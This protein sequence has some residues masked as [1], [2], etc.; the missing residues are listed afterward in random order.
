[1]AV[2]TGAQLAQIIVR[3]D[4]SVV[5][6]TPGQAQ[7]VPPHH[8]DVRKFR[9]LRTDV[10]PFAAVPLA[11]GTGTPAA[12]VRERV[13][14]DVT[15]AP[16]DLELILLGQAPHFDRTLHCETYSGIAKGVHAAAV[17]GGGLRSPWCGRIDFGA[18]AQ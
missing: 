14:T 18:K 8:G 3:V 4:T 15:V 10:M 7:G 2:R 1:M 13:Q 11:H 12:K 9:V 16:G 17:P 5:P 6:V